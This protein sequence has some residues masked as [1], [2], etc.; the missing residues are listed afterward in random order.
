MSEYEPLD[1]REIVREQLALEMDQRFLGRY[2]PTLVFLDGEWHY[3]ITA[4]ETLCGREI[5]DPITAVK[6][7]GFSG[8]S[9]QACS[10]C[11][12][13]VGGMTKRSLRRQIVKYL[14]DGETTTS[15]F[16]RDT[17]EEIL[18]AVEKHTRAEKTGETDD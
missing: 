4:E 11:S 14:D 3:P 15:G 12:P 1:G 10:E 16:S 18:E 7:S 9:T 6:N 17:L 5:P 2:D 13:P 8:P